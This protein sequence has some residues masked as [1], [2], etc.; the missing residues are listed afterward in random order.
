MHFMI[1]IN[2]LIFSKMNFCYQKIIGTLDIEIS[3][4][5]SKWISF[6]PFWMSLRMMNL[7]YS[8]MS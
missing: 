4:E 2:V 5:Y 8:K 6:N 1:S 3:L 7:G